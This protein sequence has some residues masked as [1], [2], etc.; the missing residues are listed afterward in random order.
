MS[1][2]G[3][4]LMNPR[5]EPAVARKLEGREPRRKEGAVQGLR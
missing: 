4:G 2:S 5:K 1:Y 3:M